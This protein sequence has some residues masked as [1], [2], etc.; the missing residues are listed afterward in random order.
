MLRG[1]FPSRTLTLYLIR[2][3]S[4]RIVG[5]LLMLVLILQ[6][7]QL[8]SESGEILA[9]P[10]NGSAQLWYYISLNVP[11]LVSRFLPYSVLLA[12]L[13]TFWPLNVNSEVIAMRAAGLSAHQVLAPMLLT[14]AVVS[15]V[16]FAFN[17][18]VVA[19]ATGTLKRWSGQHYKPLPKDTGVR[20][21]VYVPD[22]N[23][24][25]TAQSVSGSGA[26]TR[27][28]GVT[29]YARDSAGMVTEQLR[30]PVAVYANPGWRM[31]AT[32]RFDVATTMLTALPPQ[33]VAPGVSPAQLA[34]GKVDPEGQN[35][36][37]LG[38]TIATLKASGH[39]V[40]EL[41]AKWWHKLAGPLSA[42]LMPLLGSVAAFGLA[43]SGNLLI[44]AALGM[45]MG[46]AYFVVDNAALAMG[47][48]G[49]YPPLIAA[50]AP[51]ML[52]LLLGE[53]VLVR[54]EE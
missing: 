44:R 11:Q 39:R 17:E 27:L 21:N 40:T 7:L 49:G 37:A 12:T 34:I 10:G 53:T 14:A 47:N 51:F 4:V 38:Q 19:P 45:A 15:L 2:L 54:T 28:E 41:E 25:L 50:W 46:F 26:Q 36:I 35:L 1:L 6:A 13:L 9:V 3:F 52:F 32:A 16:S 48:F 22:G 23:N 42:L 33:V 5:I 43:R 8:L 20:S 30:S 24:I 18:T 29:W 31:A